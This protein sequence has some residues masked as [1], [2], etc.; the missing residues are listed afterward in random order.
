[1]FF[2]ALEKDWITWTSIIP[3]RCDQMTAQT[4]NQPSNIQNKEP[5]QISSISCRTWRNWKSG[6]GQLLRP[7][8][9]DFMAK[10]LYGKI[11]WNIS[12]S[13]GPTLQIPPPIPPSNTDLDVLWPTIFHNVNEFFGLFASLLKCTVLINFWSK[14]FG[15]L[16]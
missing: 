14:K 4:N 15:G 9:T 5:I 11:S 7:I 1:M 2:L 3:Q 10:Y 16:C 6:V 12:G 13:V 8:K